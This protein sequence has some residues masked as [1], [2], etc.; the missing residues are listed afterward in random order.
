MSVK[1][2]KWGPNPKYTYR[3]NEKTGTIEVSA[4]GDPFILSTVDNPYFDEC[5]EE[6][7]LVLIEQKNWYV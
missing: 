7:L 5:V 1:Y 3:R 6:G 2:Y 4:N